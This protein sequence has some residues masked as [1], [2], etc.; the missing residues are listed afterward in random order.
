MNQLT[1][2]IEKTIRSLQQ[3]K[4]RKNHQLFVLEGEKLVK[5]AFDSDFV[6]KWL[7]STQDQN[8]AIY[9]TASFLKCDPTQ[10][11]R[12]SSLTTAPGILAVV[13]TP[14][15]FKVEQEELILVLEKIQD[16]G[17]LGTIIR[18]ADAFGIKTI[19]C[20]PDTVDFFSPKVVQATMGSIFR[21]KVVE[22][23][24][25]GFLKEQAKTS[26][27]YAADLSGENIY[28]TSLK[29]PAILI[30]GNE[31]H[32]ISDEVM[33]LIHESVKIP[34]AGGAE[35]FNVSI[36]TAILLGEFRRQLSWQ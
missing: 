29:T 6:V 25:I 27:L 22:K 35:S 23:E 5:E 3:K 15:L 28:N 33:E 8:E 1:A 4:Y 9:S 17:N 34:I 10:M 24:L 19:V 36:A 14:R 16:P 7:V 13:E 21:V 11:K 32:G 12:I 20:S 2:A 30:M 31:S 18:T 26:R